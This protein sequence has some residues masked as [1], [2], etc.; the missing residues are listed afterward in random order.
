MSG[1]AVRGGC[2]PL[3]SLPFGAY[4]IFFFFLDSHEPNV[5]QK[6]WESQI[7]LC[8]RCQGGFGLLNW[9]WADIPEG[10]LSSD[11]L[12][13]TSR[14]GVRVYYNE[15]NKRQP[16]CFQPSPHACRHLI[17]GPAGVEEGAWG[18]GGKGSSSGGLA[19]TLSPRLTNVVGEASQVG[20]TL[21]NWW[22]FEMSQ[23]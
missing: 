23:F 6:H 20:F 13:F 11:H 4:G 12:N 1:R 5:A 19:A 2:I 21:R 3:R 17:R 10:V 15:S 7:H 14:I 8:Q 22:A 9:S 16:H 18:R